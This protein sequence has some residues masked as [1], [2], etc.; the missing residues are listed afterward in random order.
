VKAEAGCSICGWQ[1]SFEN[2]FA[3]SEARLAAAEHDCTGVRTGAT[4]YKV[5]G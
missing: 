1:E 2:E 3:E 4:W 5:I